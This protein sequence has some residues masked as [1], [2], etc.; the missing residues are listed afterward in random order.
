MRA[1]LLTL[2]L[3]LAPGMSP[4]APPLAARPIPPVGQDTDETHTFALLTTMPAPC[5]AIPLR[6]V[7]LYLSVE[8]LTDIVDAAP[9]TIVVAEDVQ[10]RLRAQRATALLAKLDGPVD[11]DGCQTPRSTPDGQEQYLLFEAVRNGQVF[12]RA[13]R[14]GDHLLELHIHY[15]ARVCGYGCS[16]GTMSIRVPGQDTSALDLPWWES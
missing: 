9:S 14:L 2:S 10:E 6:N 12:A 15:Q 7:T 1:L 11:A 5:A 16:A 13:E 8:Q 4:A 3:L